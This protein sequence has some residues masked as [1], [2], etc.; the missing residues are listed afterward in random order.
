MLRQSLEQ[1]EHLLK[2]LTFQ[3]SF[4]FADEGA[5]DDHDD[6]SP[7]EPGAAA[8]ASAE[9]EPDEDALAIFTESVQRTEARC[10]GIH[11]QLGR[12]AL[13]EQYMRT[14][15]AQLRAKKKEMEAKE[16]MLRAEIREREAAVI[17]F[18]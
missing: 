15:Q 14:K 7:E 9:E 8:G 16:A 13:S 1:A 18:H 6:K 3:G 12:M 2:F 5:S 11:E 4:F 10:A 17:A